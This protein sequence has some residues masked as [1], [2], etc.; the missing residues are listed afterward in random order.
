MKDPAP[1][2]YKT[3][4]VCDE[5]CRRLAAGE[6]GSAICRDENMPD[7]AT[8]CT[9][10]RKDIKFGLQYTR[11]RQDQA[12]VLA[13][14]LREQADGVTQENAQAM[15]VKIG[16]YQ[17]IA[18]RMNPLLYGDRVAHTDGAGGKLVPTELTV[19]WVK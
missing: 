9:W 11:A 19:R 6:A 12:E 15:R 7:W 5:I 1:P 16:T 8:L 10:R 2:T 17:W 13:D 4:A 14:K 18:A 3:K